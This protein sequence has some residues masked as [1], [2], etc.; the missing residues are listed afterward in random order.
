MIS[1]VEPKNDVDTD[2]EAAVH[3][4]KAGRLE[5][6]ERLYDR[7]LKCFPG[8]PDALHL[9]GVAALQKGELDF[10]AGLIRRAIEMDPGRPIFYNSLGNVY[11]EQGRPKEAINAYREALK[12]KPDYAEAHYD[13]GNALQTGGR[14]KEAVSCY[15]QALIHNPK[16]AVAYNNLGVALKELDH[17]NQAIECYQRAIEQIPD[18]I[19]AYNNLAA[20]L[21]GRN[22]LVEARQAVD[23]ALRFDPRSFFTNLNLAQL[24]Y[25]AAN[26][27]L[28]LKLL[29]ELMGEVPAELAAQTYTLAGMVNDKLGRYPEAF[30]A[31]KK[32]NT[33]EKSS[34]RCRRLEAER[35]KDLAWINRLQHELDSQT[36]STCSYPA[37]PNETTAP[38][39]LVGFPRSGTTLLQQMLS[40]HSRIVVLEEKPILETTARS[41]LTGQENQDGFFDINDRE[42]AELR[43]RYWTLAH[44]IL[45]NNARQKVVLD[46]LP[47]NIIYLGFIKR[48]FLQAKII[49][50]L[51]HPADTVLSN[52]MQRYKLNTRMANFLNLDDVGQFYVTVMSLYCKYRKMLGSDVIQVRYEDL[53]QSPESEARRLLEFL[54]LDWE[55]SVLRFNEFAQGKNINTPSYSQVIR[56]IYRDAVSRWKNYEQQLAQAI[57][58]L[59]PFIR[60]FGYS[61]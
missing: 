51:R 14:L 40:A 31:F 44:A 34:D 8:Y 27:E 49:V 16:M 52:F 48:L 58:I 29:E 9:R 6:A 57:G 43:G 24:E 10:A 13:L 33:F 12:L 17:E 1:A 60:A 39:F 11:Q 2:L 4:H 19:D 35:K 45:G 26:Y 20:I 7:I 23:S 32:A 30:E 53:V 56:P 59:R 38:V 28:S 5:A 47:L 15:R 18:F 42:A 36:I 3:H 22:R 61:Q 25:R 54:E 37:C 55:E 21:E 50:A 41:F 46:K